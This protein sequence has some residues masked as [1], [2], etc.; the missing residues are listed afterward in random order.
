MA[1][2]TDLLLEPDTLALLRRGLDSY[3]GLLEVVDA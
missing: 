2:M 3:T 1:E